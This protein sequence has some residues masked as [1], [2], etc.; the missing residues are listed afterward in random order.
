MHQPQNQTDILMQQMHSLQTQMMDM[1]N[2]GQ[3]KSYTAEDLYPYPFDHS[4]QMSPFPNHFSVPKFDKY[5]G[6]SNPI[7][8]IREF[9]ASCVEVA[10]DETYLMRL[11]P[12]SLAGPAMEWFSHLPHG[13]QSWGELAEKFIAHFHHNIERK[14][15]I[16]DLCDIK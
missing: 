7:E 13:I 10:H 15:S 6:N 5:K 12:Q 8:H 14:V 11:F 2:Q 9:F 1:Q 3:T 4:I 16:K